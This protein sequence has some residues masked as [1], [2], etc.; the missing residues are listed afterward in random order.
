[1]REVEDDVLTVLERHVGVGGLGEPGDYRR[2][3]FVEFE[4]YWYVQV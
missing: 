2:Y 3:G 1:M 4:G